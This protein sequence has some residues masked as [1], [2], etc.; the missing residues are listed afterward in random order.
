MTD[1]DNP[2]YYNIRWMRFL[3]E[4]QRVIEITGSVF[5]APAKGTGATHVR[6]VS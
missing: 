1:F 2:K 4:A 5:S 3:E 6:E